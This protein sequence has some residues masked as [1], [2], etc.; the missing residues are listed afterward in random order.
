MERVMKER[1]T[2]KERGE[3]FVHEFDPRHKSHSFFHFQVEHPSIL[4]RQPPSRY[5][6]MV[7]SPQSSSCF[8][9]CKLVKFIR[10]SL[11]K[12]CFM[13]KLRIM[14]SREMFSHC[15]LVICI[16]KGS[17]DVITHRVAWSSMRPHW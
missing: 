10:L 3:D 15:L 4:I 5:L 2:G 13:I 7:F 6:R 1:E 16:G 14:L 11:P 8:L 17:R 9:R 12:E